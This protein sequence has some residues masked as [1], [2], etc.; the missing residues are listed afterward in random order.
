MTSTCVQKST[1]NIMYFGLYKKD[2]LEI[3]DGELYK[4]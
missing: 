4:I 3:C 2:K 1:R